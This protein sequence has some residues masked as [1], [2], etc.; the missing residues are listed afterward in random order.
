LDFVIDLLTEFEERSKHY[1]LNFLLLMLQ[2]LE[3]WD[4]K[5][6]SFAT[7]SWRSREDISTLQ[8]CWQYLHLNRCGQLEAHLAELL[9][10]GLLELILSW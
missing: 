4:S 10:N 9:D 7:S 5:G 3:N 2:I 8:Q 6:Q 1:R